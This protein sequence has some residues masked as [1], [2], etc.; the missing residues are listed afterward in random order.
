M[1]NIG[2]EAQVIDSFFVFLQEGFTD[3]IA[4]LA[5]ERNFGEAIDIFFE[6]FEE[7]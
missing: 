5:M 7:I 2:V 4:V 6:L 1:E 3:K